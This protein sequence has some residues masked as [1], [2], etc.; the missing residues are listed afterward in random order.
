[1]G[2]IFLKLEGYLLVLSILISSHIYTTPFYSKFRSLFINN[3]SQI[4]N[5]SKSRKQFFK[6]SLLKFFSFKNKEV[7]FMLS[8]PRPPPY[9]MNRYF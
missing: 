7:I 1:M 6:Y 3:I 4:K 5:S 8:F 2:G 9:I